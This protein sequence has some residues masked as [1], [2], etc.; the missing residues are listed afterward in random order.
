MSGAEER[1]VPPGY[2][3]DGAAPAQVFLRPIGT[4]LP[5]GFVGLLVATALLSCFNLGWIP[6]SEQ[7]QLSIALIAFA[8]PLQALATILLFLARDAPSGAAV[9]VLS[10][11]WLTLGLL[12]LS[13]APGSRSATTAIFLFAAAGALVPSAL[14]TGVSKLVPSGVFLLVVVRYVLTGIYEKVGGTG[15]EHA[16]GWEGIVVAVAALYGAFAADLEAS[17]RHPALSLGRHGRGTRAVEQ[18]IADQEEELQRE[19]GVRQQT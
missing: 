13:G 12:L 2:H 16:A 14:T 19:P 9:G 3:L 17:V 1:P 6:T 7:H 10:V 4:P 11:T 18:S 5:L 8:F 15:W